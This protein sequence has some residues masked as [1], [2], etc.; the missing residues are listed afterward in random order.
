MSLFNKNGYLSNRA[1]KDMPALLGIYLITLVYENNTLTIGLSATPL[2]LVT[3][4]KMLTGCTTLLRIAFKLHLPFSHIR[5]FES[6]LI[7]FVR[8]G[9]FGAVIC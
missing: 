5:P 6:L 8:S 2:D 7:Q 3:R 4:V 1:P 9:C